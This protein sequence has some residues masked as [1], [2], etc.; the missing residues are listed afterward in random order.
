MSQTGDMKR[1]WDISAIALLTDSVSTETVVMSQ[2][3]KTSV[4]DRAY[5]WESD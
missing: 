5:C 3:G 1:T 2:T 4:T